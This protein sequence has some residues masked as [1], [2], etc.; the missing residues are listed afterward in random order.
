MRL[1]I[2]HISAPRLSLADFFAMAKG[3]GIQQVEIRNDI[4]DVIG[5]M[6]PEAV[7]A[8]AEAQGIT[9]L[10]INALYPFNVWSGD[11]PER[12]LR[13]AD[14]AEA[15]G[16][17]ALVMCPLNDGTPVSF[18]DLVAALEA[19][20]PILADRGL[21]GLVEPLGFPISSLR[22]KAEAIRAIEAADE[23]GVYRLLHDTFHHHLAGETEFF[24]DRTGLVH[25]S[26]LIEPALGVADML[27]EHRVL[28]D[29]QD[30]LENIPQIR[31]LL[32]AGYVGPVSLEPFSVEVHGLAEPKAAL[33]E[34]FAF[35]KANA[36]PVTAI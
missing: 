30:R 28:V 11:L 12:A 6:S 5:T 25:I 15:C 17:Q 23:A 21:T 32:A 22:T 16:A 13:L 20:K 35:V 34:C 9:I 10:A 36:G 14:Y 33:A 4:P 24:P 8:E 18:E 26:G 27:D 7:K 29:E 31:A 3:L 2:N 19:M 1:A